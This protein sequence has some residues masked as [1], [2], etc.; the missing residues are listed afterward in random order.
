[1][2]KYKKQK[3]GFLGAQGLKSFEWCVEQGMMKFATG[4]ER[5]FLDLLFS[6][7]DGSRCVDIIATFDQKE[8]KRGLSVAKQLRK[9]LD[10]FIDAAEKVVL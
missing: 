9:E 7:S 2:K 4:E 3:R 1:M 10:A 5:E 6:I 8:F